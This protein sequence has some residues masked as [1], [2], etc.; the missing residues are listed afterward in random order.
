MSAATILLV[1]DD[2]VL[3]QVLRRVLTRDGYTVVEAGSVAQALERAREQPPSLGLVDLRLP[4]GDGVELAQKLQQQIGSF[5]LILMTAYPLRLRDQPELARGFAHVLTKPLNLEELRQTI[6]TSLGATAPVQRIDADKRDEKSPDNAASGEPRPSAP[7]DAAPRK[8]TS[9]ARREAPKRRR[10]RWAVLASVVVVIAGLAVA[11]PALGMPDFQRLLK[12][13]NASLSASGNDRRASLV[14]ETDEAIELPREVIVRL[15]VTTEPVQT[16]AAPRSLEMAGSLSFEPN[17]LGRVQARFGG[18]VIALGKTFQPGPDGKTH[19]RSLR[20][21]DY[22]TKG[23]ILAVVLS[24][25][26]GEKKSELV[27]GLVQL[28]LDEGRLKDRKELYKRGAIPE[29]TLNQTRIDVSKGRNAVAKAERTLHTWRVPQEEI[30]SVKEEAR[31]IAEHKK[32]R[33]PRKETEWAK[34]EVR[35]PFNGTI[36]EKNVALGNIVDT[37]FDLYK[38]ADLRKLGVIVHAYEEDLRELQALRPGFPW[39]VRVG[40]EKGGELLDSDGV[41][42]IGLVIDPTQH[43]DPIMGRVSNKDGKLRVGQFVKATVE[44][45]APPHVV[46]L[47]ASALAENGEESV[48]F[49]QPDPAQPR[50]VLRRVSVAM[51]LRDVVYVRSRLTEHERKKGLQVVEPGEYVVTEGVLELQAAL[52]DLQARAKAQK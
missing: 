7:G 34:V 13:F 46:S 42:Q 33:D 19:E 41:Q 36:V 6:E 40:A 20:Y 51:R 14:S 49:V 16:A 15:G 24:K 37:T 11:L 28:A 8:Q 48:L 52:E 5:P 17:H 23:Q 39:Q 10:L 9:P 50:Y 1:D 35:A 38:V 30:D 43:T 4:D 2:E 45:P 29:D 32:Q 18:E 26:L 27:D 22:V 12:P 3:S 21:G 25:D 47:P 31:L 44:L